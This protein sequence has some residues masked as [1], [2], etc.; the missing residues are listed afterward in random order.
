MTFA[1]AGQKGGLKLLEK[2]GKQHFSRI[3]ALGGRPRNLNYSEL[4]ERGLLRNIELKEVELNKREINFTKA[5]ELIARTN[6]MLSTK[7]MR[8]SS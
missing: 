4:K 8:P 3:G 6:I 2:Y 1:E 7:T 5:I